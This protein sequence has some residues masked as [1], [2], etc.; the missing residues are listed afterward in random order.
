MPV[1]VILVDSLLGSLFL[2]WTC[3]C[4]PPHARADV[5]VVF[6]RQPCRAVDDSQ[7]LGFKREG[8]RD[9]RR[10]PHRPW[11]ILSRRQ[12]AHVRE[13]LIVLPICRR[14]ASCP[15]IAQVDYHQCGDIGRPQI[16]QGDVTGGS[17][18]PSRG[19]AKA[20]SAPVWRFRVSL[21]A[22]SASMA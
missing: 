6:C 16:A 21:R 22:P 15:N 11:H 17:L 8:S 13:L 5:Q 4:F 10:L 1:L 18:L 9:R 14:L 19:L 2:I 3:T 20:R 12:D 7:R